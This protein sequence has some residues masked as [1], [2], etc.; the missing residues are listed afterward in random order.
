LF[1]WTFAGSP[2]DGTTAI[3]GDWIGVSGPAAAHADAADASATIAA[4]STTK[5]TRRTATLILSS[6]PSD[7]DSGISDLR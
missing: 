5:L 7:N 3:G 1:T 6:I 4:T 2:A